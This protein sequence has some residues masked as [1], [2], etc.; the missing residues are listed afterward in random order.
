M[1][2]ERSLSTPVAVLVGSVIIALAV[3]FGP[4]IRGAPNDRA[5]PA[6]SAPI[7]T[8]AEPSPPPKAEPISP[9]RAPPPAAAP[10]SKEAVAAEVAKGL[11]SY[12]KELLDRCWKPAV[13]KQPDPPT[14]ELGFNFTFDADGRQMG[15][16]VREDRK[17]A[18]PE[19]REC[20]D[21]VVKQLTISPPG[22]SVA[23]EVPFTLP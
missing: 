4:L 16:G 12:R 14:L 22:T 19:I 10:P 11:D 6:T 23:V 7:T 21:D 20:I 18:R 17:T 8:P 9:G 15:R 2:S 3:V 1:A 5:Q 13:A